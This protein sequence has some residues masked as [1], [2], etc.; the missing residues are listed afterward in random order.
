MCVYIHIYIYTPTVCLTYDML[1]EF[2]NWKHAVKKPVHKLL[3]NLKWQLT[4]NTKP[5]FNPHLSTRNLW[6]IKKQLDRFFLYLWISFFIASYYLISAAYRSI[7]THGATR[8][9]H[10]TSRLGRSLIGSSLPGAKL[11]ENVFIHTELLASTEIYLTENSN[12][13]PNSSNGD[14]VVPEL[15]RLQTGEPKNRVS[16]TDGG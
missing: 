1:W 14:S 4:S 16:T 11:T 12:T 6:R 15:T 5:E 8:Q 7:T 13:T 3:R 9:N 10:P 2:G